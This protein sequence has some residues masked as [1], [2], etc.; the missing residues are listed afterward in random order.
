MNVM[1]ITID[2]TIVYVVLGI[3][4]VG[5]AVSLG[6]LAWVIWRVRRINLPADADILTTLRATPLS[7]VLL[8]DFLDLGL[9]VLSAPLAWVILTRLGLGRL[10]TVAVIKA[11]IP[12]TDLI[13]AMTAGWILARVIQPR[14]IEYL[15]AS[16]DPHRLPSGKQIES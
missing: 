12:F 8:L 14:H 15:P 10:R 4:G 13:P 6:L 1:N 3:I 7:V 9:D 16:S 2:Q 5:L 11:L